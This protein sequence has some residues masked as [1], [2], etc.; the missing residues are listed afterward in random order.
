MLAFLLLPFLALIPAFIASSKGRSFFLW[1]LYGMALL[2]FALPHS[3]LVSTNVKVLE[4]K[5]IED[6]SMRQ[7]PSCAELVKVEAVVCRFCQ[8]DL[9][10]VE[11][12][13][14]TR[15]K[16]EGEMLILMEKHGM[17]FDGFNYHYNGQEFPTFRAAL[18][19]AQDLPVTWGRER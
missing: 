7:C 19:M 9:P 15:E 6:G 2:I 8:R 4:K 11:M 14:K 16:P 13:P 12:A 10:A 5:S 3:L 1:W 17:H 18:E